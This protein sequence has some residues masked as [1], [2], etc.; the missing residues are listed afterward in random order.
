[1]KTWEV[2]RYG[3][4]IFGPAERVVAVCA[5]QE[6]ALAFVTARLRDQVASYAPAEY[7]ALYI[8]VGAEI[9]GLVPDKETPC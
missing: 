3:K 6:Q 1:M 2:L 7:W 8:A 4:D 5:T 9:V